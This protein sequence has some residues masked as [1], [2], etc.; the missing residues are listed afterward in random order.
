M[1]V[2]VV[3]TSSCAPIRCRLLLQLSSDSLDTCPSWIL[4]TMTDHVIIQLPLHVW[5]GE[6][7]NDTRQVVNCGVSAPVE[8]FLCSIALSFLGEHNPA[9]SPTLAFTQVGAL[10]LMK[11]ETLTRK[12]QTL[13]H[14]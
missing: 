4:K 11:P 3:G 10:T 6:E 12:S 14:P 5:N 1:Q 8:A 9:S 2:V 13:T 7:A